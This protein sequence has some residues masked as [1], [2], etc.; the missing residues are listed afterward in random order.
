M[1][2]RTFDAVRGARIVGPGAELLPDAGLHDLLLADGRIADIAPTGALRLPGD[3]LEAE[4]AFLVPGLWDHHVHA[5]QYALAVRRVPL[6]AMGSAAEAARRMA[7]APILADG[8]RI[9]VGMRDAFWPDAP[10]L[11]LLDAATGDVPTYLINADLHSVWVNS[12]ALAREGFDTPDG[13][14]REGPAFEVGLRMNLGDPLSADAAVLAM[15]A[16]A[17][18]RGVVGIVDLDLMWNA[19]SWSRR[20]AAGFDG[21]RVEFGIYPNDLERAIAAG[22]RTG[23]VLAGAPQDLIRVGPMKVITDGSLGTRTAACSH[24]YGDDPADRGVLAVPPEELLAL[25]MTATGAG[26][27]S[28]IHAIGDEANRFALDAFAATGAWGTIEH[29]QLVARSD[30]PR[31]ARLGVGASVQPAHAIDD[32]DLTDTIWADQTATAYPLRSFI[33]AG[34][35]V[36]LGSDAPVAPLDPWV[37]MAAAVFRTRDGREPWRAEET[38]P[39]E[40]ALAA[41][42]HRGSLHPSSIEV[43][44]RA[45]LVL[46]AED[47]RRADEPGLRSMEVRAT[48]LSG[49]ATHL[50]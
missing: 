36:L 49:R 11:E 32:R 8:R 37:S 22:L 5:T 14:L 20:A 4:G 34:A 17:A 6:D 40:T 29:A 30:I 47:P 41:S 21:L 25:M 15:A 43:G 28:A 31:F 35:N 16:D 45:D 48:L 24:P 10:S 27:A 50:A 13:V 33:D 39:L 18:R 44:G 26:F 38:L 1:S 3:V 23:D 7:D 42:T 19:E 9:G 46:C 2:G 12:A